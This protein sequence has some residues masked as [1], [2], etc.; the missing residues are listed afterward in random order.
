MTPKKNNLQQPLTNGPY[1]D[2]CV[3]VKHRGANSIIARMP[4][5]GKQE[6]REAQCQGFLIA[7]PCRHQAA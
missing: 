1:R 2:E 5:I 6:A 4:V 7:K 3:I